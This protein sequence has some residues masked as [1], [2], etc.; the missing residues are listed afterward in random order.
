MVER[1]EGRRRRGSKRGRGT[2]E[3]ACA[4]PVEKDRS[5]GRAA[6]KRA[7]EKTQEKGD[8]GRGQRVRCCRNSKKISFPRL[9]EARRR[10]VAGKASKM[11][12]G[13]GAACSRAFS[14]STA[15][16]FWIRDRERG[17]AR[18]ET[19]NGRT[20][21]SCICTEQS[22]VGGG[23]GKAVGTG[24]KTSK[25][26]KWRCAECG[27]CRMAQGTGPQRRARKV[28]C[29]VADTPQLLRIQVRTEYVLH[30]IRAKK[31]LPKRTATLVGRGFLTVSPV[32]SSAFSARRQPRLMRLLQR[33]S[34]ASHRPCWFL[35]AYVVCRDGRTQRSD[36]ARLVPDTM[37]QRR[38]PRRQRGYVAARG[39]Q[40]VH[41]NRESP[42]KQSAPA[43]TPS[44]S[45]FH[46]LS[47]KGPS[48]SLV[49]V[50]EQQ[51]CVPTSYGLSFA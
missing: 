10:C 45:P 20:A 1:G 50:H 40:P 11:S 31:R 41:G 7:D 51:L 8:D 4:E 47:C 42:A 17:S 26:G 34:T 15:P 14:P 28:R 12:N 44:A 18:E 33:T 32:A 35:Y 49:V 21:E 29:A 25:R 13:R 6:E 5:R 36:F 22:C 37:G 23:R 27:R 43:D 24:K 16:V 39:V 46:P 2:S 19:G 9:K 30:T 38:V 48:W 3:A